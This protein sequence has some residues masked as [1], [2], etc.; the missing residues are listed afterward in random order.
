MVRNVVRMVASEL[1]NLLQVI[2]LNNYYRHMGTVLVHKPEYLDNYVGRSIFVLLLMGL[3][4]SSM[5]MRTLLDRCGL[6]EFQH[7]PR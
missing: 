3:Y 7:F 1:L 4:N 6:R 2:Q 5:G